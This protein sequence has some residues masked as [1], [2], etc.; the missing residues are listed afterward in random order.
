[1][2][3]ARTAEAGSAWWSWDQTAW[4]RVI[5]SDAQEWIRQQPTQASRACRRLLAYAYLLG[6]PVD[7]ALFLSFERLR[8]ARTVFGPEIVNREVDTVYSL[9]RGCSYRLD[10]AGSRSVRTLI[11][12]AMLLNRSPLLADMD[13]SLLERL[14]QAV[15]FTGRASGDLY[16]L[17]RALAALPILLNIG[18]KGRVLRYAGS[19]RLL[20]P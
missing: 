14:R 13:A 3:L 2:L 18:L 17:Q 20:A 16:P 11:A 9:L 7:E 8:L 10:T 5:G 19:P 6:A 15:R 1:M 4:T 12:H